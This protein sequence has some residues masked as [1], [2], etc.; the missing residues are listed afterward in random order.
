LFFDFTNHHPIATWR[1]QWR[2]TLRTTV[3]TVL[4]EKER[5]MSPFARHT[6]NTKRAA[7][8]DP[9]L[10]PALA[11]GLA[12]LFASLT[13][14]STLA[15]A[16]PAL[17]ASESAPQ[18]AAASAA[19]SAHDPAKM[20]AWHAKRMA[21][22]KARLKITPEQEANWASFAA[23]V[24]PSAM[25]SPAM[26]ADHGAA[27]MRRPN[28]AELEKLST[29]ERLDRLRALRESRELS[30]GRF[31]AERAKREDAIRVFYPTLQPEQKKVFDAAM[32]RLLQRRMGGHGDHHGDHGD[33]GRQGRG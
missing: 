11:S 8:K 5:S 1:L 10:A 22:F 30:D 29:P 31:K 4:T 14:F 3:G 20:Q 18:T 19:Q 28:W 9:L 25:S 15:A 2:R 27:G 33:H 24:T 17:S 32:M 21:G 7:S 12:L 13:G 6:L 16:Q 26:A 23:S